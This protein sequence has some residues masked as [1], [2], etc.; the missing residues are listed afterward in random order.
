MTL[1]EYLNFREVDR[2]EQIRRCESSAREALGTFSINTCELKA[3]QNYLG[4]NKW[5]VT[6]ES[7]PY[8]LVMSYPVRMWNF[9]P[10]RSTVES[11]LSWMLFLEAELGLTL[12]TPQRNRDGERV[13]TVGLLDG[14]LHC[15]LLRWVEGDEI[16]ETA[17][18]EA[19]AI[20][21]LSAHIHAAS[22]KWSAENRVDRRKLGPDKTEEGSARLERLASDGR[23]APDQYAFLKRCFDEVLR[24]WRDAPTDIL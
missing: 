19:G 23:I 9:R 16:A 18:P 20:G 15:S 13:A 4:D 6:C 3:V 2:D 1:A 5:H 21:K 12:Q 7:G 17:V 14:E 24:M 8:L 11:Q 22:A 10:T